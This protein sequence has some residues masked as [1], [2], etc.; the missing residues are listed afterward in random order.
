MGGS[1]HAIK[2]SWKCLRQE[3]RNVVRSRKRGK[4]PCFKCAVNLGEPS[5]VFLL[6]GRW[7]VSVLK[8]VTYM[9]RTLRNVGWAAWPL[10]LLSEQWRGKDKLKTLWL[11]RYSLVL[12]AVL[13]HAL[14]SAPSTEKWE[15]KERVRDKHNGLLCTKETESRNSSNYNRSYLWKDDQNM[16][17][18]NLFKKMSRTI[19][20]RNGRTE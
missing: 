16:L 15:R 4:N 6:P 9:R 13:K 17:Y 5:F 11:W 10:L 3:E 20:R 12:E 2:P 19:L 8:S 14:G 1:G 18:E 7:K